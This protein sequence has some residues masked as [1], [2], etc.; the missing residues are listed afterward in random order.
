MALP[1]S[2]PQSYL[3]MVDAMMSWVHHILPTV[4]V[5]IE[6]VV[7]DA[8]GNPMAALFVEQLESSG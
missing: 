5:F 7:L 2:L 4:G 1:G 3:P 6:S 8:T